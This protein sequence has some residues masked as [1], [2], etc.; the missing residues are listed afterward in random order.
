MKLSL[1]MDQTGDVTFL[2]LSGPVS[3]HSHHSQLPSDTVMRKMRHGGS[4]SLKYYMFH[5]TPTQRKLHPTIGIFLKIPLN[6]C[7]SFI[8]RRC[9]SNLSLFNIPSKGSFLCGG[10]VG[11]AKDKNVFG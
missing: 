11:K 3:H 9:A 7:E 4:Q 10:F 1:G 5:L 6:F 8:K 2:A